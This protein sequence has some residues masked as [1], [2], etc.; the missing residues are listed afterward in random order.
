MSKIIGFTQGTF[1]MFHVG[2]LN[3]LTNAKKECDYL[4]VGVN[5]DD[6]VLSYKKKEVIV[7]IDERIAI[8]SAIRYVDEVICTTVL[9][10]KDAWNRIKFDR[11]FIGDDWKDNHRWKK[12]EEEMRSLGASVIYLPYTK[13]TNSTLLREKLCD[14]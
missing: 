1:D 12:T 5:S 8:V 9:D 7:P 14:R 11:L 3:L 6:L 2:H 4:I 10:K 13:E